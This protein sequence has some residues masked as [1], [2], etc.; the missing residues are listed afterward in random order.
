VTLV[1][2]G[3]L[4]AKQQ[5][6]EKSAR[7]CLL[8]RVSPQLSV[9]VT[10]T[11]VAHCRDSDL[12]RIR[13]LNQSHVACRPKGNDEFSQKRV[14]DGL[15]A[16]ER[17]SLQQKHGVFDGRN[18]FVSQIQAGS[19]F[20]G[21]VCQK[22]MQVQEVFHS[23]R[24]PAD[25]K[26]HAAS[27]KGLTRGSRAAAQLSQHILAGYVFAIL[28]RFGQRSQAPVDE[29][30]LLRSLLHCLEDRIFNKF[31]QRFTRFQH[32]LHMGADFGLNADRGQGRGFHGPKCIANAPQ[33]QSKAFLSM[34]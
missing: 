12:V 33:F 23:L 34:G 16:A 6:R 11:L 22:V 29:L 21:T 14:L 30:T 8:L 13:D 3:S 18:A 10:F 31:R 26:A 25:L 20:E 5:R 2:E 32:G 28:M 4:S 17:G 24:R 9:I 19:V 1:S 7:A 15:A 27:A